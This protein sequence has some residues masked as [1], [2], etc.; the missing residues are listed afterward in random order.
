MA[1]QGHYRMNDKGTIV[2][3][4]KEKSGHIGVGFLSV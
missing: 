4:G 2:F 1:G 3:S